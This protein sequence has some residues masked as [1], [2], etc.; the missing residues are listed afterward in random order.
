MIL[1]SQGHPQDYEGG[2]HMKVIRIHRRRRVAS[3]VALDE[4]EFSFPGSGSKGAALT[5]PGVK[6]MELY[7]ALQGL[8]FEV[9]NLLSR[10]DAVSEPIPESREDLL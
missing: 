1:N 6:S 5:I 7:S 10:L 4:S 8:E 9:G 2:V 3:C